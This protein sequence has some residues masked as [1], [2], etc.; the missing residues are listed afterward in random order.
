MSDFLKKVQ[1]EREGLKKKVFSWTSLVDLMTVYINEPEFESHV[2]EM[3]DEETV[4]KVKT[5]PV[6]K[7]RK[8]LKNV[9]MDFGVAEKDAEKVVGEY[10]FKKKDVGAIYEFV[11]DFQSQYLAT[12][13]RLEL[14]NKEDLVASV[15]V[16]DFEDEV[17]T[18][19]AT[20]AI[21]ET[22]VH[23]KKHR[24]L[25]SKSSCP[26]WKKDKVEK[27]NHAKILKTI[28]TIYKEEE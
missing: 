24:K 23:Y 4:A 28:K 7:F 12:G 14:V 11:A 10:K 17:K 18:N 21:P 20:T 8:V 1:A 26:K 16:D 9:L 13:R 5:Q 25:S 3:Q 27:D 22:T 19:K 2:M 6:K 15:I